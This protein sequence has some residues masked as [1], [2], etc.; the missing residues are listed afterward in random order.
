MPKYRPNKR[1]FFIEYV[2][3]NIFIHIITTTYK[4]TVHYNSIRRDSEKSPV[5]YT[6]LSPESDQ[7]L[8]T[9]GENCT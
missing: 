3:L 1:V 8:Q 5:A 7:D 9:A 2:G 4:H 6:N